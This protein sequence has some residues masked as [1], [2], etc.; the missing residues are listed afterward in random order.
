MH[1]PIKLNIEHPCSE[2]WDE[3]IPSASG[4]FCGSCKKTVV[5][6]SVMSDK[7][8]YQYMHNAANS[9]CGRFNNDQLN[10]FIP[11]I[12]SQSPASYRK[13]IWQ[14]LLAGTLF[15]HQAKSQVKQIPPSSISYP[16]AVQDSLPLESDM[17][18]VVDGSTSQRLKA[19]PFLLMVKILPPMLRECSV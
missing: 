8:I 11:P 15:A 19:L 1:S 10:K 13:S 12:S 18:F 14:L 9:V 2:Q 4:N 3:M 17:H 6:F 7:K 16:K 5:D